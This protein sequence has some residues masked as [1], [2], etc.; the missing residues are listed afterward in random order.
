MVAGDRAGEAAMNL[1]MK[2]SEYKAKDSGPYC[3]AKEYCFGLRT[4]SEQH[5]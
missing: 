2:S 5:S 3:E 1:I 4:H